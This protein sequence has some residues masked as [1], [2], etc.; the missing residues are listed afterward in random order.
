MSIA[1][2]TF[3]AF[4]QFSANVDPVSG[5]LHCVYVDSIVAI[6]EIFVSLSSRR[7]H[8]PLVSDSM[9]CYIY[10][11]V[12]MRIRSFIFVKECNKPK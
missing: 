11:S 4:Q 7:S 8:Y 10:D 6:F 2:R 12:V 9:Y 1:N 3:Q 5:Q